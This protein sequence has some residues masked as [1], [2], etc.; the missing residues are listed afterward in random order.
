MKE[1]IQA[2]F[3][4]SP[5]LFV[6]VVVLIACCLVGAGTLV[7]SQYYGNV[8]DDGTFVYADTMAGGYNEA[9]ANSFS[10]PSEVSVYKNNASTAFDPNAEFKLLEI[11]PYKGMGEIGYMVAGEEP[12]N[13]AALWKSLMNKIE[14]EGNRYNA[15]TNISE[16]PT[17]NIT[18]DDVKN[19]Y[20]FLGDGNS[21]VRIDGEGKLYNTQAFLK[22]IL[23]DAYFGPTEEDLQ[24]A[25][26]Y[27]AKVE[28]NHIKNRIDVLT[29]DPQTLNAHPE[30]V[31]DSTLIYIH[32][33]GDAQRAES[34]LL[35]KFYEEE[36][37]NPYVKNNKQ[38][39][40]DEGIFYIDWIKE[41]VAGCSSREDAVKLV[42]KYVNFEYRIGV[43]SEGRYV[44]KSN[45]LSVNVISKIYSRV[46][47]Q[48]AAIAIE[49]DVF[50]I[51]GCTENNVNKIRCSEPG[52]SSTQLQDIRDLYNNN[53]YKLL[54]MITMASEDFYEQN[55]KDMLTS[56]T[57]EAEFYHPVLKSDGS[58]SV[59]E[60]EEDS[61]STERVKCGNQ[62]DLSGNI[63]NYKWSYKTW[64]ADPSWLSVQKHTLYWSLGN[65]WNND[66]N[67]A[68]Y[69][70]SRNEFSVKITSAD[71]DYC[72]DREED[73]DKRNVLILSKWD[74]T[75]RSFYKLVT[76]TEPAT[77]DFQTILRAIL[78]R[79]KIRLLEVEPYDS[80]YYDVSTEA[81]KQRGLDYFMELFPWVNKRRLSIDTMAIYEFI[82]NIEDLNSKYDVIYFGTRM[83]DLNGELRNMIKANDAANGNV[84]ALYS[85][86]G[87]TVEKTPSAGFK[88]VRYSGNDLTEKKYN[89]LIDFMK[90]GKVIIFDD[91]D[92]GSDK[93]PVYSDVSSFTVNTRTF[94]E[95]SYLK[96]L[97]ELK[98]LDEY[99]DKIFSQ[100]VAGD[101]KNAS[102]ALYRKLEKP[103]CNLVITDKDNPEF[104]PLE[105]K[106]DPTDESNKNT[107]GE[108]KISFK[109]EGIPSNST[110]YPTE[111]AGK[112]K[113][114]L[115]MDANADGH[116]V[117]SKKSRDVRGV[118]EMI[119]GCRIYEKDGDIPVGTS[120]S[121]RLEAGKEYYI[122]KSISG[123]QD[124][125]G[126]IPWKLEVFNEEN[127]SMRSCEINYT[128]VKC[129]N[130]EQRKRINVLQFWDVKNGGTSTNLD[131][132]TN[133]MFRTKL[134]AVK[135]YNVTI[136]SYKTI[137]ETGTKKYKPLDSEVEYE[138]PMIDKRDSTGDLK[139]SAKEW[140]RFFD[141]YDMLI[142]G[143][144]DEQRA[145]K[146]ANFNKALLWFI[147][148]G[149]SVIFSHDMVIDY[150][151][152]KGN[153]MSKFVN[154]LRYLCGMDRY[155]LILNKEGDIN[156]EALYDTYG[157]KWCQRR[158]NGFLYHGSQRVTS[159]TGITMA[160]IKKD[161]VLVQ[162]GANNGDSVYGTISDNNNILRNLGSGNKYTDGS[163]YCDRNGTGKSNMF[164]SD[165]IQKIRV[166]NR[167]QITQYPYYIRNEIPVARTHT[168]YFEL[169][170]DEPNMATW[171][172]L[173]DGTYDFRRNDARN[174]YYIVNKGN[175]TYTGLGH[176]GGITEQE[177]ELFVNTMISAYRA[178]PKWPYANVTNEDATL[179]YN[180]DRRTYNINLLGEV[181]ETATAEEFSGD[182]VRVYFNINT[183]DTISRADNEPV[184]AGVVDSEGNQYY[185]TGGDS[186]YEI[187][188]VAADKKSDGPE[189]TSAEFA[190]GT[191]LVFDVDE[192]E[193]E[194]F[195]GRKVERHEDIDDDTPD[196]YVD[197]PMDEI[198]ASGVKTLDIQVYLS[199]EDASGEKHQKLQHSFVNIV[200]SMLFKLE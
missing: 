75:K 17:E 43:N 22:N 101:T 15:F 182:K 96:K 156:Y 48:E 87:T 163:K 106:G 33:M 169:N 172:C 195:V 114:Y 31:D 24:A 61:G 18:A 133:P 180:G 196:Y 23:A 179:S 192:K 124:Y 79:N 162:V 53:M 141:N 92:G 198:K 184:Y 63:D 70:R 95:N 3:R 37:Y 9:I 32:S 149:K 121:A 45:D 143:F 2:S 199:Y 186:Y 52:K 94:G 42:P 8:R 111:A 120:A 76:D 127:T 107:R 68:A 188:K 189:L 185:G 164:S 167:G 142:F 74:P 128:V 116:F 80:F 130:P 147:E 60:L 25:I 158:A 138:V 65:F 126:I 108:L 71:H 134:A 55:G 123:N 117:G 21:A 194:S 36:L 27:F 83:S 152:I 181:D 173:A 47:E 109:I 118:S 49:S 84:G 137:S 67:N 35:M 197:V 90:G 104:Y 155:G 125:I 175:I 178:I 97:A 7:A 110:L 154:S 129:E 29:V 81:K 100:Q 30:L 59:P 166:T 6:L 40:N 135:E 19:L 148:D 88:Q 16:N 14:N 103:V 119:R 160:C 89:E 187:H 41:N 102:G 151:L 153:Q 113:A 176:K 4:K 170:L 85:Q 132:T 139:Y 99:K 91:G 105:Y 86:V 58:L 11:V 38:V 10:N 161:G 57:V 28:G 51:Q 56:H 191:A 66:P 112:Y 183:G 171:G 77:P 39:P 131:M 145:A 190:S 73:H 140:K 144:M 168:Q 177:V 150:Q 34:G 69:K 62:G 12:I 157:N 44:V 165:E 78:S 98:R 159:D 20:K 5:R 82:G 13:L 72:F 1:K 146:D 46:M 115:Y 26:D 193:I 136:T 50:G 122:R 93:M 200:P 64:A 54:T 174:N